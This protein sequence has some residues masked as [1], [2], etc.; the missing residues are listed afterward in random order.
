MIAEKLRNRLI[1]SSIILV[2]ALL[3]GFFGIQVT[4]AIRPVEEAYNTESLIRLHILANS[5]LPSDQELKLQVRDAIVA[6]TSELFSGITTKEEAWQQLGLSREIVRAVAQE[7]I[8]RAGKDYLVEVRMGNLDFPEKTYGTLLVPAGAY[9]AMQVIIGQ[10]KGRNWWCVLFPPLC[11]I[12]AAGSEPAI[13]R[14]EPSGEGRAAEQVA[15]QWRLKY[16]DD[17]YREYGE[18]LAL[19]LSSTWERSSLFIAQLPPQIFLKH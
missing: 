4:S 1:V 19:L 15:V 10:G 13:V 5:D 17:L 6:H 18:K 7:V 16:L 3:F 9:Q 8:D 2:A 11:F 14:Q 12:E